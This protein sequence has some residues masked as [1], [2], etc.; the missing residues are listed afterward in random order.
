MRAT[1][2]AQGEYGLR[3]LRF[4]PAEKFE[5]LVNQL[6]HVPLPPYI[7]RADEPADRERYQTIFAREARAVA[8]PTAGLHF[9]PRIVKQLQKKGIG[10]VVR[11]PSTLA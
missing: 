5:A 9:S 10:I 7:H 6:G 4:S 1:V 3:R 11:L 2:E 8:A